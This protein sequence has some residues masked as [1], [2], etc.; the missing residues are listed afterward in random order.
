MSRLADVR[1]KPLAT[2]EFESRYFTTIFPVMCVWM[3]QKYG[4][5]TGRGEC[6]RELVVGIK[7]GRLE[8]LVG[9]DDRVGYVIAI[10]PSDGGA[11]GY[12]ERL[13]RKCEIVDGDLM[14]RRGLCRDC[15]G[16][17]GAGGDFVSWQSRIC[18]SNIRRRRGN[19]S[20][21]SSHGQSL[22]H[23]R[24][25]RILSPEGREPRPRSAQ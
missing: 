23:I 19:T 15:G 6:E 17:V 10:D 22:P 11:D 8:S 21:R 25:V 14:S 9:I 24:R 12:V 1:S 7:R 2:A 4:I 5:L 3:P 13:R 18:T 20:R 16:V